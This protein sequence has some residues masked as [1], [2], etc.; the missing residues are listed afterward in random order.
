[1]LKIE[2]VV[3]RYLS[4]FSANAE[5]VDQSYSEYGH[6]LRTESK[7]SSPNVA[8]DIKRI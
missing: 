5:D 8:S 2:A 3:L 4:V 1:M 6:F 7:G